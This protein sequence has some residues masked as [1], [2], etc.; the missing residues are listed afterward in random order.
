MGW[1]WV[2]GQA[3]GAQRSWLARGGPDWQWWAQP[4]SQFSSESAQSCPTLCNPMDCMDCSL[5]LLCPQ[6]NSDTALLE[7]LWVALPCPG[8][9]VLG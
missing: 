5:H 8:G 3:E 7:S 6:I 2:S 4:S 9:K 1:V